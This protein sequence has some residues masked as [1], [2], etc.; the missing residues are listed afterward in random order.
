MMNKKIAIPLEN[1]ALCAHFGHCQNFAIVSVDQNQIK[2]I[3]MVVP[4]EHQ[5][6]L[7]P[8]WVAEM[9]VTDVIAGGMGQKAIQLFHKQKINVFTGAPIKPAKE[10]TEDFLSGNLLLSANYCD[11]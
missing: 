9:G 3:D 8:R 7:Y 4:P 1:G 2:Q 5:P 11:H 10:L 6:G